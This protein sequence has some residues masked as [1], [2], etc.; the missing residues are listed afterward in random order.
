MAR[1]MTGARERIAATRQQQQASIVIALTAMGSFFLFLYFRLVRPTRR[2][3]AFSAG[4]ARIRWKSWT[5]SARTGQTR[6]RHWAA[7]ST[8]C[9]ISCRPPAY[10][11][12]L[13]AISSIARRCLLLVD[14]EQR[15]RRCNVSARQLHGGNPEGSGSI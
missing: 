12:I 13:W 3:A 7:T 2:L 6:S 10:R 4:H 1:A 14:S 11:A 5:A 8:R 9:S 15:V